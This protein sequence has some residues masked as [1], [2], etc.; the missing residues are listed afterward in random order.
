MYIDSIFANDT[1]YVSAPYGEHRDYWYIPDSGFNHGL[2]RTR[3]NEV[4]MFGEVVAV[5][6]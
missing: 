6:R 4:S 1:L 5:L 2:H 3:G